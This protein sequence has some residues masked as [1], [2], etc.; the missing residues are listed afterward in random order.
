MFLYFFYFSWKDQQ[1]N[2]R[3]KQNYNTQTYDRKKSQRSVSN[4]LKDTEAKSLDNLIC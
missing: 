3:K 1:R 2:K 4:D